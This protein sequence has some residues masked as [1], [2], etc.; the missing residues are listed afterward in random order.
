MVDVQQQIALLRRCDHVESEKGGCIQLEGCGKAFV[1]SLFELLLRE[2]HVLHLPFKFVVGN[3]EQIPVLVGLDGA[4]HAGM[5]IHRL[6]ESLRQFAHIQVIRQCEQHRDVVHIAPASLAGQVNADLRL[7]QR[8]SVRSLRVGER[9]TGLGI[10]QIMRD[11]VVLNVQHRT[12]C[13]QFLHIRAMAKAL[14]QQRCQAHG[15]KRCQAGG[16]QVCGGG[17]GGLPHDITDGFKNTLFQQVQHMPCVFLHR[18]HGFDGRQLALVHLAVDIQRYGIDL[19]C[20]G[21]HHIGG[22]VGE[23]EGI[24]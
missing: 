2:L 7:G 17:E 8:V 12:A 20:R 11:Q 1:Y 5:G 21:R 10:F 15:G 14:M 6:P 3:H 13:Q 9:Q 16:H 18:R 24:E 23:N 19:H 4:A 22:L